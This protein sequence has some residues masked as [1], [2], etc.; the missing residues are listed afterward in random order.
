MATRDDGCPTCDFG[1][2]LG[3]RMGVGRVHDPKVGVRC[4]CSGAQHFCFVCNTVDFTDL[5]HTKIVR[6]SRMKD[7]C[8]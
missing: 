6:K 7:P 1:V 8:E 3:L 5:L 4:M 2:G